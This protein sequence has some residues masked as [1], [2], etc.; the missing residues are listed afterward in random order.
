MLMGMARGTSWKGKRLSYIRSYMDLGPTSN[1][2]A[3]S[4]SLPLSEPWFPCQ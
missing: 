4:K 3:L 1:W 2:V